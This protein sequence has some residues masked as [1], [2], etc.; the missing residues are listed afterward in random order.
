MAIN[1]V[2]RNRKHKWGVRVVRR[3]PKE[4]VRYEMK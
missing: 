2:L 4:W 3:C 1:E